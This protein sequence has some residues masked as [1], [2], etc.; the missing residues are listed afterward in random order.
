MVRDENEGHISTR[1]ATR[2]FLPSER[3]CVVTLFCYRQVVVIRAEVRGKTTHKELVDCRTRALLFEAHAFIPTGKPAFLAIFDLSPALFFLKREGQ[4][5]VSA[6]LKREG[7][8]NV[9]AELKRE[10]QWN[11]RDDRLAAKAIRLQS[12][13][14]NALEAI[15]RKKQARGERQKELAHEMNLIRKALWDGHAVRDQKRKEYEF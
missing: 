7:Q 3:K 11:V 12:D 5:N 6:E 1:R 4:W 9:S 13:G 10:G 2:G 14:S 8:W 15:D